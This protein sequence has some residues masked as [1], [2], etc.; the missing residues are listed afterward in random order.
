[1][2]NGY[3]AIDTPSDAATDKISAKTAGYYNK[4]SWNFRRQQQ[5][6]DDLSLS[7]QFSGQWTYKNLDSWEKLGLGGPNAIRGYAISEA[8][9][10]IGWLTRLELRYNLLPQFLSASVFHDRGWVMVNAKPYINNAE[11][12]LRRSGT[13]LGLDASY[14]SFNIH[15]A[16]AWRGSQGTAEPDKSPRFWIQTSW[17]F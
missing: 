10:D 4:F 17:Q 3:L 11:N 16:V 15:A 12:Y 9:G 1:M 14:E 7:M 5:L 13:G 2:T 6:L 8:M